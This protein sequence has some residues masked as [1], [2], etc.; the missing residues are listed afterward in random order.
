[1]QKSNEGT[2]DIYFAPTSLVGFKNNWI[3][4]V[5]GKGWNT[6]FRLQGA[7]EPWFEKT[8]NPG[9]SELVK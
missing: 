9:E 5:A 2:Y 6:I 7:L 4:T 3:Q 1:M 8:W